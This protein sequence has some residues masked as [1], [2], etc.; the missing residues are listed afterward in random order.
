MYSTIRSHILNATFTLLYGRFAFAHEFIGWCAFGSAWGQR[1]LAISAAVMRGNGVLADIGCGDGRLLEYLQ[2]HGV[3]CLGVE[4]SGAMAR[5]AAARRCSVVRARSGN[6]P[7]RT[8]SVSSIVVTYPGPW[9]SDAGTQSELARVCETG[10]KLF[11]LLGGNYEAGC[12]A[13]FRR[14]GLGLVYGQGVPSPDVMKF[15]GFTGQ[16]DIW[17]DSWGEAYVWSGTRLSP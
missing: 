15:S 11:V 1:R 12:G 7:F 5:R 9:I 8:G 2:A 4:P 3:S 10:G 16:L 6:L 13:R 17:P 14:L